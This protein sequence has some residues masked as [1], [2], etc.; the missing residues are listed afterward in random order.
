M[1]PSIARNVHFV[2]A[3]GTVQAAIV[4]G[5]VDDSTVHLFVMPANGGVFSTANVPFSP[6]AKPGHWTWPPR[7]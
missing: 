3:Y 6:H 2:D 7:V 4:T 1:K 5:V